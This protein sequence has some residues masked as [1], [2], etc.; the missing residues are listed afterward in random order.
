MFYYVLVFTKQLGTIIYTKI[1]LFHLFPKLL[2]KYTFLWQNIRTTTYLCLQSPLMLD[3]WR[4]RCIVLA[5]ISRLSILFRA[6]IL[7][8]FL[9]KCKSIVLTK[10][11]LV[12]YERLTFISYSILL[13][14][15]VSITNIKDGM[16]EKTIIAFK[17]SLIYQSIINLRWM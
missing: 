4:I 16:A 2:I 8:K 5:F 15:I 1:S 14:K 9:V 3:D 10:W 11:V 6:W 13:I 7:I 17:Q 12:D